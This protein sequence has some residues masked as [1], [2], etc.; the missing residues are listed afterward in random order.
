MLIFANDNTKTHDAMNTM[1]SIFTAASMFVLSNEYGCN[2][3]NLAFAFKSN[4]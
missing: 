4:S 2:M 1:L 3:R